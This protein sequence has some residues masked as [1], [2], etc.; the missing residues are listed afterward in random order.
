MTLAGHRRRWN[1]EKETRGQSRV[2]YRGYEILLQVQSHSH[3]LDLGYS[4]ACHYRRFFVL[5]ASEGKARMTTG[6]GLHK[7][8]TVEKHTG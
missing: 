7:Q 6:A 5:G 1:G 3:V 8:K 2:L 4:S